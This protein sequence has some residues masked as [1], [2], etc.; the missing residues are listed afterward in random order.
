MPFVLP[1]PCFLTFGVF[2]IFEFDVNTRG[3]KL[4]GFIKGLEFEKLWLIDGWILRRGVMISLSFLFIWEF[5]LSKSNTIFE[6]FS[7][8][9]SPSEKSV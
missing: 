6:I 7:L 4:S 9:F 3:F 1:N 2:L 8:Y 5:K